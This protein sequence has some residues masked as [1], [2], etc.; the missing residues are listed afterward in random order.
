VDEVEEFA[1]DLLNGLVDAEYSQNLFVQLVFGA[2]FIT[3]WGD[4]G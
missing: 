4:A 2:W 1:L 3:C